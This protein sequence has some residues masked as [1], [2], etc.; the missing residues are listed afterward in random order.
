MQPRTVFALL[1]A[2]GLIVAMI[3]SP[4]PW[5][6]ANSPAASHI[7]T[8]PESMDRPEYRNFVYA[9]GYFSQRPPSLLTELQG[10]GALSV[11]YA[12]RE[13]S[14]F[15]VPLFATLDQYPLVLYID[16]GRQVHMSPL[17]AERLAIIEE[18]SGMRF[19]DA[20]F[21]WWKHVWGLIFPLGL[22][23]VIAMHFVEEGRRR[24]ELGLL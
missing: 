20:T 5:L 19:G 10:R 14:I 24:R 11:G 7:A 13:F 8:L 3:V 17:N 21:A 12:V 9:M 6:L 4:R 16:D 1:L 15:R 2:L 18:E 23:G 22:I